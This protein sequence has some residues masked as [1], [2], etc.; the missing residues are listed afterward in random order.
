MSL[1]FLYLVA[2]CV[3]HSFLLLAY[4]LLRFFIAF[5]SEPPQKRVFRPVCSLSAHRLLPSLNPTV[6]RFTQRVMTL[7]I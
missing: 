1:L 4:R 5:F 3:A 7:Y 2:I 6:S